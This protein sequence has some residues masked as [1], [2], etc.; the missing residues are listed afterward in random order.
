MNIWLKFEYTKYVITKYMKQLNFSIQSDLF[1][2]AR[3]CVSN[4]KVINYSM[5]YFSYRNNTT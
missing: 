4:A 1:G 5:K 2:E 3:S